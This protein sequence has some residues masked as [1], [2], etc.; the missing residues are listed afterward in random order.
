MILYPDMY[1]LLDKK[2][3]NAVHVAAESGRLEAFE[4]LKARPDFGSLINEQDEEGNTPMHLAAIN[5][6]TIL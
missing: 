1:E 6:I 3:R 2:G 4:F 5:G